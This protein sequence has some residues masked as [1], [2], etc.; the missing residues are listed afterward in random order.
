MLG[1][2]C[3]AYESYFLLEINFR[4]L[5]CD[6]LYFLVYSFSLSQ[7]R[8]PVSFFAMGY[9]ML[10]GVFLCLLGF[11]LLLSIF[12]L[13]GNWIMLGFVFLFNLVHPGSL[14]LSLWY[15]FIVICIGMFGELLEFGLQIFQAKKYGSTGTGTIGGMLGAIAGAIIMAPFFWGLGAIIGALLGAWIGCFLFELMKGRSVQ[16]A[17]QAAFGAMIGRFLG[18]VCKLACGAVMLAVTIQYIWPDSQK[19]PFRFPWL[20][21]PS[22]PVLPG[23]AQHVFSV[24][25]VCYC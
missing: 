17:S 14:G 2:T 10:V 7:W 11:I 23:G 5:S 19:L 22:T 20:P 18:T 9:T 1:L 13:P 25:L 15:W 21:V 24:F 6:I 4:F 8:I 12:G 16:E 3:M